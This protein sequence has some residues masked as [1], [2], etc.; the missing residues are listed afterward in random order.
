MTPLYSFSVFAQVWALITSLFSLLRN[1]GFASAGS[2]AFKA[3]VV[4]APSATPLACAPARLVSHWLS[5]WTTGFPGLSLCLHFSH[6]EWLFEFCKSSQLLR[7]QL[8]SQFLHSASPGQT[9]QPW[10]LFPTLSTYVGAYFGQKDEQCPHRKMGRL[11]LLQK[12]HHSRFCH[13]S[14][15]VE[16]DRNFPFRILER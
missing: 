6:L 4:L 8:R 15:S 9:V 12:I 10:R 5:E 16:V 14:Y 3:V 11:E 1:L 13:L 2:P 7:A